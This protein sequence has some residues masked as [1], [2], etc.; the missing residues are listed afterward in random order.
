MIHEP[1]GARAH[2]RGERHG[3]AVRVGFGD[4]EGKNGGAGRQRAARKASDPV[5][6]R[7]SPIQKRTGQGAAC[8]VHAIGVETVHEGC[9]LRWPSASSA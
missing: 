2:A 9:R 7:G 4:V 8:R 6:G 5:I 1:G 3:G